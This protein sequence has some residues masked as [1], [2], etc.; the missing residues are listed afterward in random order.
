MKRQRCRN[1]NTVGTA[2]PWCDDCVRA[3]LKGMAT[4]LGSLLGMGFAKWLG[5][6]V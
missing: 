1:C 5:G 4:G 6:F 2:G 3:F